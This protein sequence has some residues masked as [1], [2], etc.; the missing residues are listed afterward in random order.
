M[1][2]CCGASQARRDRSADY[3]ER[4]KQELLEALGEGYNGELDF[5]E[6]ETASELPTPGRESFS[7]EETPNRSP[8]HSGTTSRSSRESPQRYDS[9]Y[10]SYETTESDRTESI[11]AAREAEARQ[12]S[13]GGFTELREWSRAGRPAS[14]ARAVPPGAVNV[15]PG[16]KH[17]FQ[18]GVSP[19]RAPFGWVRRRGEQPAG[20]RPDE[21]LTRLAGEAASYEAI[22]ASLN[23]EQALDRPLAEFLAPVDAVTAFKGKRHNLFSPYQ[24]MP[25][26]LLLPYQNYQAY[27]VAKR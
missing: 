2:L 9:S 8:S 18:G 7:G 4:R 17:S 19:G 20:V 13:D 26:S 15:S 5:A 24:D 3:E 21:S 12:G 10:Q 11:R 22:R 16:A 1:G 6:S 14:P 27:G 23:V 25:K